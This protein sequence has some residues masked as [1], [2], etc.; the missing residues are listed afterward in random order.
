MANKERNKRSA[1]KA[2]AEERAQRET[3][4]AE[5]TP[6]ASAKATKAEAKKQEKSIQRNANPGF[7][8]RLGA[9]FA[10][11]RTEMHRVVWPS[12]SELAG[13]SVAVI[14]TIIFFGLVTWLVD[15]GI[16][17]GLVAFTGLRG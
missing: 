9:N 4:Q 1:R 17:A 14:A 16:V 3:L 5:A 2:R 11:V 12:S 8:G 13:F 10:G 6:E 15:T 7:F